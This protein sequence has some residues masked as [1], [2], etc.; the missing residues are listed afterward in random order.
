MRII[1]IFTIFFITILNSDI[2]KPID[3]SLFE[4]DTKKVELGKT[5]FFDTTLSSD[6]TV[7]CASCHDLS[8]NGADN[9]QFSVGVG[10]QIGNI[11][12]PT[13]F[14]SVFNFRQNWNGRAKDLKSQAKGP[15]TDPIEMGH[16]F[17]KLILKLKNTH[18]NQTFNT[19]YQD[20]ITEDN[21][22]D[23][24]GEFVK[25]LIT[26]DSRF[27]LYLLGQKDALTQIE[28]DGYELFKSRG[29]IACHHGQN[30][31]GSAYARFSMIDIVEDKHKGLYDI[32]KN[33]MDKYY[34]KIPSLRNIE[35]TAPYFHTGDV[36][37]LEE[38]VSVMLKYQVGRIPTQ[39]E[40]DKIVAFL[41]T[42]T[43]K[44]PNVE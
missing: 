26:P 18:Y 35:L 43:G 30:I 37:T 39:D 7:S 28:L 34:F 12:V 32:T 1:Y 33:E 16:S 42:L 25:T 19:I 38:A 31:G 27:D 5:L 36:K 4:Y 40:I 20:G 3:K 10:N 9:K 11:N 21:I 2:I 13:V 15:I 22:V 44:L 29:C 6:G 23:A 17:D 24:I 14:N 41:K 8:T